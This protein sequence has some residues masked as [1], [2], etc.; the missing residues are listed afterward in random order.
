MK[1]KITAL[2]ILL[3]ASS[4]GVAMEQFKIPGEEILRQRFLKFKMGIFIKNTN[5]IEQ[6]A[7]QKKDPSEIS[8]AVGSAIDDYC[9]Y[10][11]KMAG[12]GNATCIGIDLFLKVNKPLIFEVLLEDV[13]LALEQLK[14]MKV[15]EPSEE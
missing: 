11:R 3:S 10:L 13:P 8:I 9:T 2:S 12:T 1:F 14:D 6:L 5:I 4:I 7:D 15:Y